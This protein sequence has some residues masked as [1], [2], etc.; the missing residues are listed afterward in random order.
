MKLINSRASGRVIVIVSQFNR[1]INM[2]CRKNLLTVGYH[3]D[4]ETGMYRVGEIDTGIN[5]DLPEYIE[6]YG[7]KGAHEILAGLAYLSG[8]VMEE[9]RKLNKKKSEQDSCCSSS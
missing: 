6:R 4:D 3:Y 2:A 1:G 5:G 7:T 8:Q 9:L